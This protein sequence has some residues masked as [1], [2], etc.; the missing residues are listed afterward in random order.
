MKSVQTSAEE[1]SIKWE[2][3]RSFLQTLLMEHKALAFIKF[4]VLLMLWKLLSKL[5]FGSSEV[6]SLSWVLCFFLSFF[7]KISD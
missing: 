4:S 2:W 7:S 6:L 5:L 1:T 3:F